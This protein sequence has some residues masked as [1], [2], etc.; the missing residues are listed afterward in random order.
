MATETVVHD[1]RRRAM[2]AMKQR[3]AAEA[4]RLQQQQKNNE[5]DKK[6]ASDVVVSSK[7]QQKAESLPT[8]SKRSI[9]KD[10]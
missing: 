4:Q 8:P 6:E 10:G 1:P 3:L 5:K 7:E 9:T 2:D